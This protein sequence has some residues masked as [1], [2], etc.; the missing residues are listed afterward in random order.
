M[1]AQTQVISCNNIVFILTTNAATGVITEY[2]RDNPVIYTVENAS[3]TEKKQ[4]ELELLLRHALQTTHPFTD[5]FIARVD[6]IVPFLPLARGVDTSVDH[7]LMHEALTV[8]KIMIEREQEKMQNP[9]LHLSVVQTVS[10]TNKHSI[11]TLAVQGSIE[12]AGVRSIQKYVANKMSDQILHAVLLEDGGIE[13]G[14][15]VR[16]SADED[17]S[18]VDWRLEASSGKKKN[19]Q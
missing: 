3:E 10:A 16:Y 15:E 9:N 4:Q 2:A 6:R 11:A 5:A 17:A 13:S 1:G 7:A 18:T 12:E 19:Q 14:S 8:A